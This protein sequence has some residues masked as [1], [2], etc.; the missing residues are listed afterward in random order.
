VPQHAQVAKLGLAPPSCHGL[1]RI[2][3][4]EQSPAIG[5]ERHI[6]AGAPHDGAAQ[7]DRPGAGGEHTAP[8]VEHDMLEDQDRF[9]SASA[10]ASMYRASSNVAGVTARL[11]RGVTESYARM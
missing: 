5:E 6:L 8:V 10:A 1:A 11:W 4:L 9:G 3:G 7:I 2:E